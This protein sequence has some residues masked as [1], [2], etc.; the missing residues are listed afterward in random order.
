MKFKITLGDWSDDGHGKTQVFILETNALT[1]EE[2]R[3]AYFKAIEI[4]KFDFSS[5]VCSKYEERYPKE[6]VVERLKDIGIEIPPEYWETDDL[7]TALIKFIQIGEP[8]L[9][10]TIVKDAIPSFEFYG[11]DEKERHI[12]GIGYGLFGS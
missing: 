2:V 3:E 6:S 5:K 12:G 4:T 11:F 7:L 10:F 1:I 9:T 8:V